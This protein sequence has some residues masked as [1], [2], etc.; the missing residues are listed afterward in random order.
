M[1]TLSD[2]RCRAELVRRLADL[3]PDST[4]RWGRM[5]APQMVCH[6]IDSFRMMTGE[7]AVSP[8]SSLLHRTVIKW[9][10]LYAPL[11]W[12]PGI[13]TRPEVDQYGAGTKPG[14]FAA[15]MATLRATLAAL[16]T[17]GGNGGW[18]AHPIFGPMSER[19]WFRWAYLH[20]DHHFRQFGV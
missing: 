16:N 7:K 2:D 10:A 14:D 15:D 8:A 1:K 6:V 18:P 20:T 5:S 19:A 3:R 11:E 9:I 17:R 4:R 12:P 13:L